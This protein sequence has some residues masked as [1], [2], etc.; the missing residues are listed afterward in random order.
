MT[1]ISVVVMVALGLL[2]AVG[3][4]NKKLIAQKDAEIAGLQSD[5]TRLQGEVERQRQMNEELNAQLAGLQ[6]ENRVLI[7][8]KDDLTFITLDGSA[9]FGTAQADLTPEGREVIDQVWTVLANYPDRRVLIEGHTDSRPIR[10]SFRWKYP[11]NWELSSARA[12]AVLHHVLERD[13]VNPARLAAVGYAE[14]H[15]VGDNATSEGRL[16]NRRVVITIGSVTSV[17]RHMQELQEDLPEEVP[18]ETS[19]LR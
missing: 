11:S 19:L 13:D 17:E 8:Q 9:T 2:A 4:S 10:S 18:G 12:H 14:F 1:R 15:P 6:Q 16:L 7:Q 5:V 3:C